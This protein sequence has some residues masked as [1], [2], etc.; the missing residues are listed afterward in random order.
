MILTLTHCLY[1]KLPP[2]AASHTSALYRLHCLSDACIDKHLRSSCC[3]PYHIC[4]SITSS[5]CYC[6]YHCVGAMT[7]IQGFLCFATYH[8]GC[9]QLLRHHSSCL[10]PDT[11]LLCNDSVVSGNRCKADWHQAKGSWNGA[12]TAATSALIKGL[13]DCRGISVL[14]KP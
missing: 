8:Q 14:W 5:A 10:L 13:V 1:R 7:C 12:S 11:C 6:S 9:N 2:S 4:I 3:C